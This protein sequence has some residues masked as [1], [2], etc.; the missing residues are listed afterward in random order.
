[1]AERLE[2]VAESY[3]MYC[4]DL[5]VMGLNSSQIELGVCSTCVQFVL[6]PKRSVTFKHFFWGGD[7][8]CALLTLHIHVLH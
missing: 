7:L 8:Y 5:E 2:Q 1:M 6:D 4:H 3:E